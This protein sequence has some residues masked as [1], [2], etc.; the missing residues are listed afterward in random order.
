MM[1]GVCMTLEH[2]VCSSLCTHITRYLLAAANDQG[3]Y[4][5]HLKEENNLRWCLERTLH[6]ISP[7]TQATRDIRHWQFLEWPSQGECVLCRA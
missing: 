7:T 3:S 2:I 1:F 6:V 4:E 5:V